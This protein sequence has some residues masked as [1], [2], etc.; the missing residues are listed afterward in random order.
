MGFCANQL[1]GTHTENKYY[2][3]EMECSPACECL[4]SLSL[5]GTFGAAWLDFTHSLLLELVVLPIEATFE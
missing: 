4:C 2:E 3:K 5:G 1:K